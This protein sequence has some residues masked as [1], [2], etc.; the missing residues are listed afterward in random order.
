MVKSAGGHVEFSNFQEHRDR[1]TLRRPGVGRVHQ[2]PPGTLTLVRWIDRQCQDFRLA[3]GHAYDY[4][5]GGGTGCFSGQNAACGIGDE[6]RDVR[7]GPALVERAPV[8]RGKLRAFAGPG[9]PDTEV[10]AHGRAAAPAWG[11]TLL[12]CGLASG[13]RK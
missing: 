3:G 11:K 7:G 6:R 13:G 12:C 9:R 4:K 10:I 8:E 5:T 1:V 2:A